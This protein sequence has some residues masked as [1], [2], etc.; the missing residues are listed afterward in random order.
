MKPAALPVVPWNGLPAP[1]RLGFAIGAMAATYLLAGHL[2]VLLVMVDAQVKLVWAPS[3]IA[4]AALWRWGFGLWPGVLLGALAFGAVHDLG[5]FELLGFS[6]GSTVEAMLGAWLLRRVVHLQPRFGRLRDV[7]GLALGGAAA[8]AAAGAVFELGGLALGGTTGD[9]AALWWVC[10][11]GRGLGILLVTPVLLAWTAP[12]VA[13]WPPRAAGE[14]ALLTGLVVA[15]SALV[16]GSMAE[17]HMVSPLP[18]TLFPLLLWAALRFG[19]RETVSVMLIGAAFAVWG[20][21]NGNGPFMVGSRDQNMVS[22]YLYLALTSVAAMALAAAIK[23]RERAEEVLRES[24]EKYRLLVENQTD[25]VVKLDA[26]QRVLFVSPSYCD[27]F[28]RREAELLSQ[29][30]RPEAAEDDSG[31]LRRAWA[32]LFVP[33]FQGHYEERA[34]TNAGWRWI[35]WSAKAVR[36]AA[37]AV[38]EVVAAGR[39]VTERKRAEEQSRQHLQQLAH[40]ARISA[41]GEMATAIAHEINQPLT[42]ILSYTQASQRLLAAD[43]ADRDELRHAMQRVAAQ[44]QRA[45]EIIRRLRSFVSKE[46]TQ[47]QAVDVNYLVTEIAGL[48]RPEARQSGIQIK[49]ELAPNLPQ[50]RVD[51]IQIQQ[52]VLNLVRNGLDAINGHSGEDRVLTVSTMLGA[53][54][55]VVVAVRD[56]GPGVDAEAAQRIFEPF[57]TTKPNGMGIGLVISRSIAEAHGGRLSLAGADASGAEFRLALPIAAMQ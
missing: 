32:A 3:G 27:L 54:S 28:G 25:L 53:D 52:V 56:T 15:V 18:Y 4:L 11:L 5:A 57:F 36:D 21:A 9:P 24:E 48:A 6:L 10:W 50:V 22:L 44:A 41:L 38:K 45:G 49:L 13:A 26:D 43:G 39:D 19:P 23:E 40:V 16:F 17:R 1:A 46:E 42:A 33:P 30:F 35:A 8:A 47:T 51:S 2:S 14:L 37:G 12:P 29:P 20:T 7:F 31:G 55:M 34:L